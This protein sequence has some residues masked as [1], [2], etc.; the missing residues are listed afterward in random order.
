MKVFKNKNYLMNLGEF[1]TFKA[2]TFQWASSDENNENFGKY[3]ESKKNVSKVR[4]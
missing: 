1:E 2:A 4:D 3:R